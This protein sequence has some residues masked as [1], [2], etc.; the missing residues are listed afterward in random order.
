[1]KHVSALLV[2]ALVVPLLVAGCGNSDKQAKADLTTAADKQDSLTVELFGLESKSVFDLLAEKHVVRYT[3]S[4]TG[5]FVKE[6]DSVANGGGYFWV[7]T[8]NDSAGTV[9]ADQYQTKNGDRIVWH[10]RRR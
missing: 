3:W 9:P 1:M 7:Y 5:V 8:V 6:I 10:F 2:F 4:P